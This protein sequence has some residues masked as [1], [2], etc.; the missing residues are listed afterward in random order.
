[1]KELLY[2]GKFTP[3]DDSNEDNLFEALET[4]DKVTIAVMLDKNQKKPKKGQP[5]K[6]VEPDVKER[7]DIV[8]Y[9]SLKQLLNQYKHCKYIMFER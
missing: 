9:K 2:V 1:M 4:F 8:Y 3:W 6:I 7:L 5:T